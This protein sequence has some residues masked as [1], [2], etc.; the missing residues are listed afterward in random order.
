MR[1][2]IVCLLA[3]VHPGQAHTRRAALEEAGIEAKVVGEYLDAAI[4]DIPGARAELWVHRE[5]ADR[6]LTIIDA[7]RMAAGVEEEVRPA[8]RQ[9]RSRGATTS[10][11]PRQVAAT[12]FEPVTSR[13]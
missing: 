12:G 4:G 9:N 3:A 10:H 11:A 5:D 13:L 8:R 6:A 7:L 1:G 2:D